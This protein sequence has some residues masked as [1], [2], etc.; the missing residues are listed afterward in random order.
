MNS[1]FEKKFISTKDASSLSGYNPDY[2]ARLCRAGKI[3]G[4]RIGRAWFVSQE[5]LE[6]FVREQGERKVELRT[7]LSEIRNKEYHSTR[8]EAATTQIDSV[9]SDKISTRVL[10]T[11]SLQ[12][13]IATPFQKHAVAVLAALLVLVLGIYG[14][15]AKVL[16]DVGNTS[17]AI[18]LT[19]SD[20]IDTILGNGIQHADDEA[21]REVAAAQSASVSPFANA[22]HETIGASSISSSTSNII[23]KPLTSLAIAPLALQTTFD[24][25]TAT[26]SVIASAVAAPTSLSTSRADIASVTGNA[27]LSFGVS[28]RDFSMSFPLTL[29]KSEVGAAL[30]LSSFSDD[31]LKTYSSSVYEWVNDTPAVPAFLTIHAYEAG[32]RIADAIGTV[33]SLAVAGFNAGTNAWVAATPVPATNIIKTELALGSAINGVSEGALS[34]EEI[35]VKTAGYLAYEQFAQGGQT[36]RQAPAVAHYAQTTSE[37]AV[38]GVLGTAGLTTQR[39]PNALVKTT[40]L[41]ATAIVPPI[42]SNST[43][44]QQTMSVFSKALSGFFNDAGN[45]LSILFGK[46]SH[47]AVEP[48]LYVVSPAGEP[49]SGYTLPTSTSPIY[50]TTAAGQSQSYPSIQNITNQTIQQGVQQSYVDAQIASLRDLI[51]GQADA[52]TNSVSHNTGSGGTATSLSPSSSITITS[53]TAGNGSFGSLNAGS[54]TLATL[55]VT[56]STTLSALTAATST[57]TG[58]VTVS[59]NLSAINAT[60]TNFYATLEHAATGIFDNLFA[61]NS[62]STNAT[63]TNG[64]I[65]QLTSDNANLTNATSTNFFA[66]LANFGQGIFDTITGTNASFTNATTSSLSI[67]SFNGPLQAN[68]GIV[69]A[70]TSIGVTYGGTGLTS[71]PAYGQLLVGNNLGGYD[72]VATSS[73]NIAVSDLIGTTDNLAEGTNNLYFTDARADARINATSSIGTLTA[74]PNLMTVGTTLTGFL[75][76][77][78]G[79]LSTSLIDLT[80][81]VTNILPVANGGTGSSSFATNGVL[82]GNGTNGLLT[83]GQGGSN[84]VLVANNGAPSFSSNVTVTNLTSTGDSSFATAGGMVGI[85]TATPGVLLDVAG[86]ARVAN[87]L[88]L[89]SAPSCIGGEALQTDASGNISCGTI[90][91]NGASSG[92]GWTTNEIGSVTLSTTTDRVAIGASTTPYAKLSIISGSAA[93]TTLALVPVSAQTANIIDI[94]NTAGTLSTVFTSGGRLG[95]GTTS[96]SATLSVNGNTLINGGITANSL[97]TSGNA[98]VASLTIGTLSGILKATAGVVSTSLV[99]LTSDISGILSVA[100]GGTGWAA[101][102]AGAIP[103]GNGT[104]ALSTTTAG[105]NGQ[106]LAFLNGVPTWTATTTFSSGTL[107][108]NGQTQGINITSAGGTVTLTPTLS[109]TLGVAGGGTG[110]TSFTSSQLVYGNGTNNLLSVA[111]SSVSN[112]AGINITG[113]A[114]VVGAGGLNISLSTV[115]IANGG[116]GT[117]TGGVTNG[118]EYY[119]GATLTNGTGLTFT[120]TNLGIGSTTPAATLGV[121]GNEFINGNSTITGTVA[122]NISTTNALVVGSLTGFLKANAGVVG[123]SLINLASDVGTSILPIANGGTATSTQITNGINYFD[124]T[125]ITSSSTLV[126][127]PNG[128]VGI[129]TSSPFAALSVAGNAYVSGNLT[130]GNNFSVTNGSVNIGTTTGSVSIAGTFNS[131]LVP[132]VNNTYNLGSPAL[133]WNN[134]Y[135]NNINVNT[136]SAASTTISGTQS[137]SFTINTANNTLD[138]VPMSLIFFR[139]LVNPNAVLA[140]NPSL[141]RF[142]FN[143]PAYFSNQSSTT[144]VVS[145]AAQ[146]SGG[147]TADIFRAL[148]GS[149]NVVLNAT[150]GDLVGVG[151]SSPATTLSVAGN[152]YLTGGLGIGTVNTA[153]GTL[154]ATGNATVGSLNIGSLSGFLKANAG[155]VGTSLVNLASDITGTLGIANGG[156]GTTTGGVT[157]GV[158]YYNGTNLTNSAGLTYNGT[159][160]SVNNG[161]INV[162]QYSSYKQAGNTVLYAS[163][164]NQSLTVGASSAAGWMAATSTNF[165]DVAIGFNALAVTPTTGVATSN[166]AV[167]VGALTANSIGNSNAA[168]G[169]SALVLNQSGA[170]NLAAGASALHQNVSGVANTALGYGAAYWGTSSNNVSVGAYSAQLTTTGTQNTFLGNYAAQNNITGSNSVGI[171]YQVLNNNGSATSSVAIGYKAAYGLAGSYANQGGV[172]L[173]YEAGQNA[174]TSSDYNTLLGYLSGWDVTTGGDNILIGAEQNGGGTHITTGSNNISLGYNA[175]FPSASGNNQLNIGNTIFGTILATSTSAGVPTNFS[176]TAIGIGSTTPFARL[177]VDT[178]NLG[179]QPAFSV[180]S[181]TLQSLIVTN[182]GLVGIGTTSPGATFSVNGSSYFNN[183]VIATNNFTLLSIGGAKVGS[184]QTGAGSAGSI[185]LARYSDGSVGQVLTGTNAAGTGNGVTLSSIG[186][187]GSAITLD[188]G[189]IEFYSNSGTTERARFDGSGDFGIGTTTP[190]TTLSVAGNGYLTGGLGI[191]AVNTTAGSIV[192]T[193]AIGGASLVTTGNANVGSLTI[194]S[195][196]GILKANAG[197]V[198]TALVNL[199]SDVTNTLPIAN[200]GTGTT[201]GGVTNGVEYYNGTTLTNDTGFTYAGNGGNVGI[202]STTPGS[203]LSIGTTN[204]INFSTGT[205]TF[206]STGGINLASGCYAV[207][208]VCIGSNSNYFTNSGS[209][210]YLNT[211]TLLGINNTN[212]QYAV[213]AVGG[214]NV[215][216]YTGY[217]QGSRL[218]AYAS[219]TNS[220][221]FFGFGAGGQPATTT[222]GE[223]NSTAVGYLAL[224][225]A[226][227]PISGA[228]QSDV[229]IGSQALQKAVG[230]ASLSAS[231]N[232]AVGAQALLNILGTGLNGGS[233]NTAIGYQS[234]VSATGNGLSLSRDNTAVGNQAVDANKTGSYNTGIGSGALGNNVSATNT[235]AVGYFAGKGTSSSYNQGG[236]Y[237]GYEAGFGLGIASDYNTLL[238]YQAGYDVTNGFDNILIGSEVNTGGGITSGG[239]NIS[240]GFNAVFP[241]ATASNQLNIGN[242]IFGTLIATSSSTS[243]PT[244]FTGALVGIASTS[245][246]A[247][248]SIDTSN[249]GTSPAFVVGSSTATNLIVTNGGLVG[250]GTT[251]PATTLSVAG[252]GYL[253]G[254]LGIGAVNTTAGTLVT[255]GNANIGG[256]LTLGSLSG[257][258]KANAGVVGVSSIN[259]ASD[260]G[261]SILPI[262]NGGTATSTGGV[263]NGV[264]YYNGTTLTNSANLTYNGTQL[265]VNNGSI[266]VDQYSSYKQ[267]GNTV[268]YASTTNSSIAV[269]A[270]SA[271]TWMAATSSAFFDVAVGQSTLVVAPTSGATQYNSAIGASAL[272]SNTTGAGSSAVGAQA[273]FANTTGSYNSAVGTNALFTNTTGSQNTAIGYADLYSNTTGSYNSALGVQALYNNTI[274]SYNDATGRNALYNNTTGSNNSAMGYQASRYNNSAT[275]TVAVGYQTAGSVAATAY[276]A[277]G[278]TVLGYQAGGNFTTGADYNTLLGYQTGYDITTGNNNLVLGTEQTTGGGITTGSNNILLGNGVSA[279]LVQTGSNQLNIGNLIFG[280]NVGTGSTLS[281]GNVGIGTSTPATNFSVIG[282]GYLTGGLGV[283]EVNTA[284]NTIDVN[285]YGSYK[286]AGNTVLYASTTNASLSVGASAAAGWMTATSSVFNDIAIG[287]NALA[288]TP[289]SGIAT[290][291]TAIGSAALQYNT[292]GINNTALGYQA[293]NT[294]TTGWQNVALGNQAL[295]SNASAS[296]TVAIGYKAGFG[297]VSYYNQGS[298]YVGSFAGATAGNSSDYNTFVGFEAGEEVTTGYDNI[299]I[300]PEVNVGG[301]HVTTGSNNIGLGYNIVFPG[302]TSAS[303]QLNIGNFIFGTGLTA[304]SSGTSIPSTLTGKLGI[305]TSSPETTLTVVGAICAARPAGTQTTACGTTNG[306][307]YANTSTLTGG[308]DVAENYT[309]SDNSLGAGDVISFDTANPEDVNRASSPF[310]PFLGVVSTNPALT[311]GVTSSSTRSVALA[312]RVPVKV[313]TENGAINVGDRL[314]LSSD[315]PGVAV[316]AIHSGQTIGVALDSYDG[317]GDGS[318]TVFI[319]A[320]YWFAPTD[321]SINSGTGTVNIGT[322]QVSNNLVVNGNIAANTYTVAGVGSSFNSA[323][324]TFGLGST[325]ASSV[326]S[327]SNGVDLY[328]LATFTL[329]NVQQLATQTAA[330]TSTTASLTTQVNSLASRVSALEAAA[331]AGLQNATSS[332]SSDLLSATTTQLASALESVGVLLQNGIAQFN[333]LV[334][335]DLVFSKDANGTSATGSGTIPA[336]STTVQITNDHML[337]T[338]QLS[339]TPTS[340]I[341]GNWYVSQ[342]QDGSF[343]VNLSQAQASDFTFDY[344]IVQTSGQIATSTPTG[345]V[346][347]TFSWINALFGNSSSTNTGTTGSSTSG[348]TTGQP[349]DS[350]STTSPTNSGTST[351]TPVVT[352]NGGAAMSI[353]QGDLFIDPGA[354]AKDV[355]GNDISSSI[356][357]SGSVDS[358]TPGIYTLT[359]TATDSA[360][361]KGS[362]SRVVTVQSGVT[363]GGSGSTS[364]SSGSTGSS[365]GSSGA[366]TSSSSTDTSSS[367]S[368]TG[369]TDTS[370]SAGTSAGTSTSSSTGGSTSTSGSTDS[371]ASSSDSSGGSSS[372][373]GATSSAGATS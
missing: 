120:G 63:T 254:G 118:V 104:G 353:N 114:A 109:G 294:N 285:Q 48:N 140:W 231:F 13:L 188:S 191:G 18:A 308:Y 258:L 47:L 130:V 189:A 88:T 241:S 368:T 210:T 329:T 237:L 67:G 357:V 228:L 62:T 326:L 147:Q 126:R 343:S 182:G 335:R 33:P 192:A 338:S 35:G 55:G 361:N 359:Y 169:T 103:Y 233:N 250:I 266:N 82:Y 46:Q 227:A 8:N 281:T 32:S 37:N 261:A 203:L 369:S 204:G 220:T 97:I 276:N 139:G 54:T 275:S 53:I 178:A 286:Q 346:G 279:G 255:T 318:I 316:K 58:D 6:A 92:G 309:T 136:I 43:P 122:S 12:P 145:L 315:Q 30:A 284:A 125:E 330:L 4:A 185:Y 7:T 226:T 27:A 230:T 325:T 87:T 195:L 302:G 184:I 248:L 108:L 336:G 341:T 107:T 70:T 247:R 339:I 282:N 1:P 206:S 25:A 40:S 278:Y 2:L 134:L 370:T 59:G 209:Q 133:Y 150:A 112:G 86:N 202:G 327:A 243:V 14:A 349:I 84:T 52:I 314:M 352:L 20:G 42:I 181:S 211:G 41:V 347:S 296:N 105:T 22:A 135:A 161:S 317:T 265:S 72:Q 24:A 51:F 23:A 271:A 236:V 152:G 198:G 355:S 213:D 310:A 26:T 207:N 31:I 321:L 238:G 16:E 312:G 101:I 224:S 39:V 324:G 200:G 223:T 75:K 201:T 131:S 66:S 366:S 244:T 93:T 44:V 110:D 194:G 319:S 277:Q 102:Q 49:K 234:L 3:V 90:S 28:F 156:T 299:L 36:V 106:V 78:A 164:T 252:N 246:L 313:S 360:G 132:S 232:T 322:S 148:D 166:T 138:T 328:K 333:T 11:S 291:N 174:A 208:G 50:A 15:Q 17:L 167:G 129:G 149:G 119:N 221:T 303:N 61:T 190:A 267:A 249:L 293:L 64:Y 229:A 113:S 199:N 124:G 146:A 367:S 142:E 95:L 288:T 365:S 83:T 273:L 364:T 323:F 154:V 332:P 242:T 239:N 358:N 80:T 187:S 197:V 155:V 168:F 123:A 179:T 91:I 218:L 173:G 56:G 21:A 9:K 270:S 74:A 222:G 177:S 186:G 372:A 235:T 306:A 180:G 225:G 79:A 245:P 272:H 60:T 170:F 158:E 117:T 263:T 196:S 116:T 340:P 304:T 350:A 29:A 373:S 159:Q 141:A 45:V 362:A 334:V 57:F 176:G 289:T 262:A 363:A 10:E 111:T 269:G 157:N 165:S 348:A 153:A 274:G 34:A 143:Q 151:T 297:T 307:I 100:N 38:L 256:T 253:T 98:N 320:E 257:I 163:T 280:T 305:G 240:L 85:G 292:S 69:S 65:S 5:S 287:T 137:T 337:A 96:P 71:A 311:L 127:L 193:G 371:G 215:D 354:T 172:Y 219:T 171:G 68:N 356:V 214:I 342:K 144:T 264:E 19:I 175:A 290:A 160:L 89:S 77:N 94:Y 259:L 345:Y 260:V 301:N 216:Q 128:N 351:S 183:N 73:L 162:D 217:Y 76:A 121:N 212:P 283:G 300:G 298:V 331:T 344:L 251:T 295:S 205:S 99:S 81:D 115:G 268:L